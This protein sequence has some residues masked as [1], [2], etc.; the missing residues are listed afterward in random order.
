MK[1][2]LLFFAV[3]IVATVASSSSAATWRPPARESVSAVSG[4]MKQLLTTT[5]VPLRVQ[6]LLKRRA[7]RA[8]YVPTRLPSGYRY[9]KHENLQRG[10]F[11]LYFTCC[12]D[13]R[14]LIGFDAV[15]VRRSEPCN[16]GSAAKEFRIG[17]IVVSWNAGHNDQEAWRCIRRGGTRLL[18]TVSGEAQRNG[19]SWR[20]PRQLARMVAYARPIR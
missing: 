19:T 20:M 13:S 5:V 10:G 3:A 6:R 16:Q 17:G 15:L 8:A 14:P 4:T 1:A 9:F 7:P 2:S 18:L 11:D 12:D